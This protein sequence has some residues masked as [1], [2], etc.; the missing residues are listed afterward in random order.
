MERSL[1][2]ECITESEES[3]GSDDNIAAVSLDEID[4]TSRGSNHDETPL[5]V[6][7][8]DAVALVF[9]HYSYIMYSFN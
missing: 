2:L 6:H 4:D 1:P 8:A 7:D 5:P 3:D 9:N